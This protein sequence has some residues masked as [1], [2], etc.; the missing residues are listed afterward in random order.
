MIGAAH[1]GPRTRR[2]IAR[3][4]EVN[5]ERVVALLPIAEG[6]VAHEAG[7]AVAVGVAW[8]VEETGLGEG[9]GVGRERWRVWPFDGNKFSRGSLDA[10]GLGEGGDAGVEGFHGG[11]GWW[12]GAVGFGK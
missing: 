9:A 7:D 12:E 8:G 11:G 1:E 2:A 4:V 5:R 3:L 6:L 10:L